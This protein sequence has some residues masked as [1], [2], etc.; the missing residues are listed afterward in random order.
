M[1]EKKKTI[2]IDEAIEEVE[3]AITRLA[4]MHLS[5]AKILVKEL[6]KEKGKSIIIKAIT[7]YGARIGENTV[8]GE[9][10][11]PK[12]GVHKEVFQNEK[13]E[14]IV[15]GCTLAKV[16]KKY[17]ELELGALYCFVDPAKS[18]TFDPSQKVIHKTCEACGD[19]KCTLAVVST[20]E[21]DR[22]IFEKRDEDLN[23]LDPY[24]VKRLKNR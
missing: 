19:D 18:M 5:Y 15:K 8:K 17:D 24:L 6:G 10:D 16:F 9:R 3:I 7:E 11:L 14:Y 4:L 1:S 21:K 12:Y 13:G 22:E 23:L 2:Q 20:S